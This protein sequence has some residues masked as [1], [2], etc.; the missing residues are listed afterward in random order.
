M[1]LG[2]ALKQ[3]LVSWHIRWTLP[4]PQGI[5]Q[6]S[7]KHTSFRH[8]VFQTQ[9]PHATNS[10]ARRCDSQGIS[11]FNK[12]NPRHPKHKRHH[13]HGSTYKDWRCLSTAEPASNHQGDSETNGSCLSK[14]SM[15]TQSTGDCHVWPRSKGALINTTTH[16]AIPSSPCTINCWVTPHWIDCYIT[17]YR[18][19]HNQSSQGHASNTLHY[20]EAKPIESIAKH[21]AC[22]QHELANPVMDEDTGNLLE[23][24]AFLRHLKFKDAL[25]L[26]AAN[27]FGQLAQGVGECIKGTDMIFFIH[28]HE[29]P[30][31]WFKDVTCIRFFLASANRGKGAP[32][33]LSHTWRQPYQLSWGC[34]CTHGRSAADKD[35]PQQC[36][37]DTECKICKCRYLKLSP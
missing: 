10:Y 8:S 15:P 13:P 1:I 31:D 21:V 2:W 29:V 4:V 37:L 11:R 34:G 33:H 32:L 7:K 27:E 28:K 5:C 36:Y 25:N 16:T 24:W 6:N 30:T 18:W 35:I 3:W 12:S 22:H 20:F 14:G 23:Y 26:S 19:K 9:V 17:K